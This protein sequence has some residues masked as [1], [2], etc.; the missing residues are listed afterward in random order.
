LLIFLLIPLVYASSIIREDCN[1]DESC[2]FSIYKHNDSHVGEC[3]YYNYSVCY[4]YLVTVS[5]VE[6]TCSSGFLLS[7]YKQ[8]DTHVSAVEGYYNYSL[9]ISDSECYLTESSCGDDIEIISLYRQND[10]HVGD[11]GYYNY[12]LCCIYTTPEVPEIPGS[13]GAGGGARMRKIKESVCKV[14]YWFLIENLNYTE[15]DIEKLAVDIKNRTN[16]YMTKKNVEN[17][18]YYFDYYCGEF[19]LTKP[20]A[21]LSIIGDKKEPKIFSIEEKKDI[22]KFF[23]VLVIFCSVLAVSYF[24]LIKFGIIKPF[25]IKGELFDFLLM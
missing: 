12:S 20:R 18:I 7:L 11:I 10:S 2:L 24:V 1:S 23:I 19:N 25:K 3:G 4:P 22:V 16:V 21:N 5:I 13:A 15:E 9:C 17:Y 14:I 8:N 6:D